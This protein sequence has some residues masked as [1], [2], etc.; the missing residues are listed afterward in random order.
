[1]DFGLRRL[2]ATVKSHFE[3]C[4][5]IFNVGGKKARQTSSNEFI[6]ISKIQN[7]DLDIEIC[8]YF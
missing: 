4:S 2:I 6:F 5:E 1:M 3:Y 8:K 7:D